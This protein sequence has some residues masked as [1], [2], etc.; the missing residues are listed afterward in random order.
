MW[1]LSSGMNYSTEIQLWLS[2]GGNS[3]KRDSILLQIRKQA[4]EKNYWLLLQ[5]R[6]W[7]VM[8]IVRK[9]RGGTRD[10]C[11]G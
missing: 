6:A 4:G 5:K 7:S 10:A 3:A 11:G 2:C 1:G 9:N 8:T